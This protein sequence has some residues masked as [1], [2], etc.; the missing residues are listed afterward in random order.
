MS[1]P[2]NFYLIVVVGGI[3]MEKK[4]T[5]DAFLAP[6]PGPNCLLSG[7]EILFHGGLCLD[8]NLDE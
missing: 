5:C 3:K 2:N 7:K 4:P 1:L 6:S 8:S